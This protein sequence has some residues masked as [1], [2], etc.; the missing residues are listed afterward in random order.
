MRV[1][2]W[3]C[4]SHRGR[5]KVADERRL[6]P[7]NATLDLLCRSLYS[8]VPLHRHGRVPFGP[9]CRHY[10]REYR[11]LLLAC[12]VSGCWLLILPV[13]LR[14]RNTLCSG[15]R[16]AADVSTK[17]RWDWRL[18]VRLVCTHVVFVGRRR[19]PASNRLFFF[20]QPVG[21][22]LFD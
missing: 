5:I 16:S 11:V 4:C 15:V 14:I 6:C 17:C 12:R 7:E 20:Y 19:R 8:L 9:D 3:V 21:S 18:S 10:R 2:P 13:G 22:S 1:G